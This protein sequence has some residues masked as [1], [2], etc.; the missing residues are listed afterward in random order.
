[1][2]RIGSPRVENHSA[3]TK[4]GWSVVSRLNRVKMCRKIVRLITRLPS[5]SLGQWGTQRDGSK[6]NAPQIKRCHAVGKICSLLKKPNSMLGHYPWVSKLC[7]KKEDSSKILEELNRTL[8]RM[9]LVC[10]LSMT[11][12][13]NAKA[14]V[15]SQAPRLHMHVHQY[16]PNI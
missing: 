13:Y 9:N 2:N 4:T 7:D 6:C 10:S 15:Q 14:L 8:P 12:Q 5:I 3:I 16:S 1:M 11:S